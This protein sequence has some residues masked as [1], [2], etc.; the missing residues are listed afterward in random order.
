M[1]YLFVY[2]ASFFSLSKFKK[3]GES[4]RELVNNPRKVLMRPLIITTVLQV[5][6]IV[7]MM[8][9]A[10]ANTLA[11]RTSSD[12]NTLTGLSLTLLVFVVSII[13]SLHIITLGARISIRKSCIRR[14][15]IK[16]HAGAWYLRGIFI[17]LFNTF[18]SI[19]VNSTPIV[20][21]CIY[22]LIAAVPAIK[23]VLPDDTADRLHAAGNTLHKKAGEGFEKA[24]G[25]A[26]EQMERA[27]AA[28]DE[29][30][31]QHGLAAEPKPA[32]QKELVVE[33]ESMMGASRTAENKTIDV[34]RICGAPL[35]ADTQYCAGCG[36]KI[37]R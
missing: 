15:E 28:K 26:S 37:E 2:L 3:N 16:P 29:S 7:C 10:Q 33:T 32:A 8:I 18:G 22:Y 13:T 1:K 31:V 36:T 4:A 27:S 20:V 11:L 12:Q 9:A 5:I 17:V 35:E 30:N 21:S 25:M 19:G 23:L 6:T 34:C 24:K 14:G